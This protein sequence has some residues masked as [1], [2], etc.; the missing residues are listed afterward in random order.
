L[1]PPRLAELTINVQH[2]KN[3]RNTGRLG[4]CPLTSGHVQREMKCLLWAE[5]GHTTRLQRR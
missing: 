4:Q 2:V 5:S 3:S 1:P